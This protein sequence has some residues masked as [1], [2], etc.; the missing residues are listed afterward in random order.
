MGRP[1]TV[2]YDSS[3]AALRSMTRNLAAELLPR[4]IR[5]NAVQP[6]HIDSGAPERAGIPSQLREE[7]TRARVASTPM[8]RAGTPDEVARAVE[9][10][11]FDATFMTGA[12]LPIDGGWSQ[13]AAMSA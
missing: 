10:L 2:T 5:V 8:G 7:M 13:L 11:A 12:E 9:F 6:G 3:K 4:G 1:G